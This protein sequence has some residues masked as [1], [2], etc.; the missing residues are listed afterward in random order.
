MGGKAVA[1]GGRPVC[2]GHVAEGSLGS[3]GGEGKRDVQTAV[4]PKPGGRGGGHR[5]TLRGVLRPED[6]RGPDHLVTMPR[7]PTGEKELEQMDSGR[8]DVYGALLFSGPDDAGTRISVQAS[9]A[10]SEVL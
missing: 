7:S 2:V 5:E 10:P 8:W 3:R 6:V 9:Q 1:P 4:E